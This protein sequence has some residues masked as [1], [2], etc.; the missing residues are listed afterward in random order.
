MNILLVNDD[1][2]DSPFLA[3][4][5]R[6][7]AARGAIIAS[8][9]SVS[10]EKLPMMSRHAIMMVIEANDIKPCVKMFFTPCLSR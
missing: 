6:A 8:M 2:I 10:S 4:L 1:G 5:C 9:F 7:A 3:L